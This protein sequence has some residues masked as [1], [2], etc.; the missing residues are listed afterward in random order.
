VPPFNPSAGPTVTTSEPNWASI[1]D[2]ILGYRETYTNCTSLQQSA[3]FKHTET[4]LIGNKI[5]KTSTLKIGQE[6]GAKIDYEYS[7]SLSGGLTYK[8]SQEISTSD[9]VEKTSQETKTFETTLPL[10]IAPNTKIVMDHYWVRR[11]VSIPYSGTVTLDASIIQNLE[12]I[13]SLSQLLTTPADRTFTFS[14]IVASAGLLEG[15]TAAVESRMTRQQC[16][17]S[18]GFQRMP[19]PYSKIVQHH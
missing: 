12:G 9:T 16:K 13:T 18:P 3:T 4:T 8:F 10:L 6:L 1:P 17:T 14:G 15:N 2:E 19:E 11:E 5:S 7:D